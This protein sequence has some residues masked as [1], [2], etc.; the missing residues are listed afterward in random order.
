MQTTTRRDAAPI[1]V[2]TDPGLRFGL[3][4][5]F[6]IGTLLVCGASGLPVL[7]TTVA[8]VAVTSAVAA[9]LPSYARL[10]LGLVV[11][12]FVTGFFLNELGVLTFH[13]DDLVRLLVVVVA[14]WLG[15]GL[16]ARR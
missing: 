2:W 14:T 8:A 4:H 6:L 12:A 1:P 9:G 7:V 5:A 16:L 13:R 11:W 10:L 15:S 3:A